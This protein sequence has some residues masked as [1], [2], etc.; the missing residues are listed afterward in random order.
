LGVTAIKKKWRKYVAVG[1]SFTEGLAD[2]GL[3]EAYLGWADRLAQNLSDAYCTDKHPLQYANL[4]VRGRLLT[5][6]VAE[7]IPRAIELQPDLVSL[8][9]G[10]NDAMRTSFDLNTKATELEQGVRAL[11]EANIDVLLVAFG[12]PSESTGLMR[13]IANRFGGLNSA[14]VAIA[15]AYDCY[16]LDFWGIDSF[17]ERS[18]W[19]EDR[20][21]L[22]PR[23]HKL[24]AE[25][26][27]QSLGLRAGVD[28]QHLPSSPPPSKIGGLLGHVR[29]AKDHGA[30]WLGRR[31][32]GVSSGDGIEPKY[33]SYVNVMP[34]KL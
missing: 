24:T 20:L 18:L 11:R 1:D 32:K 4:A 23:G 10:V 9:G 30:P 13:L 8:A 14:T 19:D 5:Q 25:L 31:I 33:W 3:G 2:R 17:N 34:R 15:K 28:L 21:H 22:S 12:D 7:Q 6:M 16:L 29:W 27:M 26:G